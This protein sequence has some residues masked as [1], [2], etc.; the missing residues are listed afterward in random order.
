VKSAFEPIYIGPWE[1]YDAPAW[2][3]SGDGAACGTIDIANKDHP[4]M[5]AMIKNV[6]RGLCALGTVFI[7]P[8]DSPSPDAN[9]ASCISIIGSADDFS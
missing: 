1:T 6:K 2:I 8:L 5:S 3:E 9:L 4:T 7:L